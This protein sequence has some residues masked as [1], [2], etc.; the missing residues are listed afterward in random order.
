M[1]NGEA[2]ADAAVADSG[3]EAPQF[4]T[5]EQLNQFSEKLAG[6]VKAML[7]RVPHMVTQQLAD[8]VPAPK[9]EP[10]AKGSGESVDPKA[11]VARL[12]KEEREAL[13]GERQS[14]ERQ[15]IRSS[16]EQEL[17]NNGANPNAVKLAAD[18][19]M[20]RNGDKLSV[21][22]NELGESS[23]KYTESEYAEG[24]SVGD[25]VR[26]FLQSDEGA[27]VVQP[28]VSPSVRGIPNGK[29]QIVGEVVKMTRAE[30]STADPKLLM[31]GRVMFTD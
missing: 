14:I 12:L 25:F 30:A 2:P 26:G 7:G 11:E 20:M 5:T 15:R 10:E 8:S 31:S 19:L 22:S 1:E 21:Q 29:S 28:K 13:A 16:L 6:D 17:V 4:V 18:S 27:A 24:V 3:A 23:I 9:A